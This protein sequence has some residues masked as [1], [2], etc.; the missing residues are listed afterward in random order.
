MDRAEEYFANDLDKCVEIFQDLQKKYPNSPRALYV[1]TRAR[2][3]KLF[4]STSI[5]RDTDE[6]N[7]E[8]NDILD[9]YSAML[10]RYDEESDKEEQDQDVM[11]VMFTSIVVHATG[12]AEAHNMTERHNAFTKKAMEL[13]AGYRND[14]RYHLATIRNHILQGEWDLAEKATDL[15]LEGRENSFNLQM[16]KGLLMK[17]TGRK[18]EGNRLLRSLDSEK[19]DKVVTSHDTNLFAQALFNVGKYDFARMLIQE[20]SKHH[21]FLSHYQRPVLSVEKDNMENEIVWD[22]E[23]HVGLSTYDEEFT[24]LNEFIPIIKEEALKA[25]E[26]EAEQQRFYVRF[27]Q[28][29]ANNI[30]ETRSEGGN[31]TVLP[32]YVYGKRERMNCMELMPK[33]CKFMKANFTRPTQFKLGVVKLTALDAKT[34]TLPL[35]SLTNAN[36]RIILP[37]RVPKD[38]EYRVGKDTVLDLKEGQIMVI[39]NS[40]EHIFNNQKGSQKA[41][42]LSI[43]ILHPDLTE[44]DIK[45]I[46]AS[47]YAK[48]LFL[49]F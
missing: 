33:T 23:N 11:P 6:Y 47:D 9:V 3:S 32:L 46:Q 49:Q 48:Q 41:V 35:D 31:L 44:Q 21:I 8:L 12:I 36:L 29:T 27:Y 37:V 7:K 43:D 38:F 13:G 5:K 30:F 28:N 17:T 26:N 18:K 25:V 24:A 20:S 16:F 22:H 10:D 42:W 45:H 34:K 40:Y 15:A 14:Q 19:I 39:D 2:L 4:N 1:G